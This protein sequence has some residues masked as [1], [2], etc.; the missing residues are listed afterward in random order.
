MPPTCTN[1]PGLTVRSL[2]RWPTYVIT[3][4]W[5][6]QLRASPTRLRTLWAPPFAQKRFVK[7]LDMNARMPPPDDV[8]EVATTVSIDADAATVWRQIYRLT[9]GPSD[10]HD[11]IVV[12]DH[13]SGKIAA[14]QPPAVLF[15]VVAISSST[16]FPCYVVR[17]DGTT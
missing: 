4:D 2:G 8:R 17:I 13:P 9:T 11:L 16:E 12:G 10:T 7:F 5:R 1:A 14:G 6:I 15:S 3:S